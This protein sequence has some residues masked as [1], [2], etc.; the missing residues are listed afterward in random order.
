MWGRDLV[1]RMNEVQGSDPNR[2]ELEHFGPFV[3]RLGV[4]RYLLLF[5]QYIWGIVRWIVRQSSS[6][7]V[8]LTPG[9][10]S[11][12]IIYDRKRGNRFSL[13]LRNGIDWIIF[14]QVF[15][16]EDYGTHRF[17]RHYETHLYYREA[18]SV[19]RTPLIIDCGGHAGFASIYF[20]QTFPQAQIVCIEPDPGNAAQA[21]KNISGRNIRVIEAAISSQDG[22]GHLTDPGMGN[23]ARRVSADRSGDVKMISLASV[24]DEYPEESFARTIVKIDIEG[25]E[26]DLFSANTEWVETFPLLIIELHDWMMI[27]SANS[28]NFLRVVAESGRDFCYHGENVFSFRNPRRKSKRDISA[29]EASA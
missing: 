8:P 1:A 7:F 26:S 19:G 5:V 11:R 15:I 23:V 3:T 21:R 9:F 6:R 18:L 2:S 16:A 4:L 28:H 24:L 13:T 25:S 22:R 27:G 29:E 10:M 14:D 20:S 17:A 12:Q